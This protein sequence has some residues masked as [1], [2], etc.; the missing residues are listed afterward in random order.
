[1]NHHILVCIIFG[2]SEKFSSQP[3][4]EFQTF[5]FQATVLTNSLVGTFPGEMSSLL[6][7]NLQY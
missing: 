4:T 2:L 5:P 7:V 1:M 6:V 3:E